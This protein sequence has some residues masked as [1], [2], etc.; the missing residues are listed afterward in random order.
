MFEK[1]RK[2]ARENIVETLENGYD[3]YLC[4]LHNEAFNMDY[5]VCYYDEA[6]SILGDNVFEAIGKIVDY[7][8]DNFG[9][10][11]TDF[12]DPCAVV[13]M[14]WYIIGEEELAK[15]FDGCKKYDEL[16]NEAINEN[17]CRALL[18]WLKDNERI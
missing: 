7:E 3:G 9:K 12:T 4:D 5:Y 11:D 16:W 14:L 1:M 8:K 18:Q 17:D 13:N 10:A 6:V 15:M 2:E